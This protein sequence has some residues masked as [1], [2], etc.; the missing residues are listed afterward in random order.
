MAPMRGSKIEA[1]PQKVTVHRHQRPFR[2]APADDL[3][4]RCD[5]LSPLRFPRL[6]G[7]IQ[8]AFCRYTMVLKCWTLALCLW[9]LAGCGG[10]SGRMEHPEDPQGRY[11]EQIAT[12]H[13]LLAQKEQWANR[14]EWEV[15]ET[16]DGWEV[17]A[18]RIEHPERRGAERYLPWGYSVI[19]VDRRMEAVRYR[20][21]G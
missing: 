9:C 3:S 5:A 1:V 18:W 6:A 16:S 11:R 12:A 17:I 21:K 7:L 19:E 15:R 2:K 13:R 14:V 10:R 8:T 20:R 4:N